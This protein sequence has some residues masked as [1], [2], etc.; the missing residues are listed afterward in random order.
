MNLSRACVQ[1]AEECT[2]CTLLSE[3]RCAQK[4]VRRDNW[5]C[6]QNRIPDARLARASASCHRCSILQVGPL[7]FALKFFSEFF[8]PYKLFPPQNGFLEFVVSSWQFCWN[9]LLLGM[10]IH[11]LFEISILLSRYSSRMNSTLVRNFCVIHHSWWN[12][13]L[14]VFGLREYCPIY[15]FNASAVRAMRLILTSE[16]SCQLIL[17]SLLHGDV[18]PWCRSRHTWRWESRKYL[19][20]VCHLGIRVQILSSRRRFSFLELDFVLG[21][22]DTGLL[23]PP[24]LLLEEAAFYT[25][26][27]GNGFPMHAWRF[28]FV[29]TLF[30]SFEPYSW[31]S[32]VGCG[33]SQHRL[34]KFS[35]FSRND[36]P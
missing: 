24:L 8:T 27:E 28:I 18:D 6:A 33:D 12:D 11:L 23:L 31:F 22:I 13:P 32:T 35:S 1:H 9:H 10:W 29:S 36:E 20:H 3:A 15:R 5:V 4:N 16:L 14:M 17:L 30:E 2:K 19:L 21:C 25:R 7:R 34:S 26:R